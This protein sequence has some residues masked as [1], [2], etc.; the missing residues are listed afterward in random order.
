VGR[1]LILK[2]IAS[3]EPWIQGLLP[4]DIYNC[5]YVS[6]VAY[7]YVFKGGGGGTGLTREVSDGY[8]SVIWWLD[9]MK[10]F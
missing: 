2:F 10:F 4:F 5:D 1:T 9:N 7:Y 6:F 3:Y 8:F